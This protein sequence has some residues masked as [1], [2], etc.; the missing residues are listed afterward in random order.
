M[1][2]SIGGTFGSKDKSATNDVLNG[3]VVATGT[4]GAQTVNDPNAGLTDDQ[5]RHRQLLLSGIAKVSKSAQP[6]AQPQSTP[7]QINFAPP[8][9]QYQPMTK[10]VGNP[11]FGR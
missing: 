8:S 2:Q 4:P 10:A 9:P 7:A 1:G 6:Q 5:L 3:Q 11:F